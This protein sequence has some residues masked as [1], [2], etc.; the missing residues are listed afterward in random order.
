MRKYQIGDFESGNPEVL[1]AFDGWDM[2]GF[3]YAQSNNGGR[4]YFPTLL[5]KEW[6]EDAIFVYFLG[7]GVSGESI[8]AI[9]K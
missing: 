1:E 3:S 5:V 4:K 9:G 6:I 2:Y 8:I 7:H